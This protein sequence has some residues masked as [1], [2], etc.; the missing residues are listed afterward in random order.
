MNLS[1]LHR[2]SDGQISLTIDWPSKHEDKPNGATLKLNDPPRDSFHDAVDALKKPALEICEL[3][4][5]IG[6]KDVT[7]KGLTITHKSQEKI[8]ITISITKKLSKSSSPL[9]FTSPFREQLPEGKQ[10]DG[11][12]LDPKTVKL[13]RKVIEEAEKY[14]NG[15]VKQLRLLGIEEELARK[16]A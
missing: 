3:T 5:L 14:M 15:D 7:V 11:T 9:N 1:K 8:G 2:A 13:V 10:D 4:D 6:N 16:A 12:Y